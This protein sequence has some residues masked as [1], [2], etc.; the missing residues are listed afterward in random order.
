MGRKSKQVLAALAEADVDLAS[1][2]R[3]PKEIAGL[4]AKQL[5]NPPSS[6]EQLAALAKMVERL[7]KQYAKTA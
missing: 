4:I 1:D 3:G 5:K 7:Q 2:S 6:A